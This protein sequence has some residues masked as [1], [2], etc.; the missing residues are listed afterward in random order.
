[1]KFMKEL[2]ILLCTLIVGASLGYAALSEQGPRMIQIGHENVQGGGADLYVR[3]L[4]DRETKQEIV[5]IFSLT[6]MDGAMSCYP[7]GRTW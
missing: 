6:H 2:V 4:H 5:C 3:Y 7:T 1:M